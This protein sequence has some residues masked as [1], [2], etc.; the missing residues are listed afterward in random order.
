M[1]SAAL[2]NSGPNFTS[3]TTDHTVVLIHHN[4]RYLFHTV[5]YFPEIPTKTRLSRIRSA[6]ILEKRVFIN[7]SSLIHCRAASIQ[8]FAVQHVSFVPDG[9]VD[10]VTTVWL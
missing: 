9:Q 8:S 6:I 2:L 4:P 1:T 7:L 3:N 10:D 5:H